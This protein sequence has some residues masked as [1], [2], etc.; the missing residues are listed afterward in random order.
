MPATWRIAALA[1]AFAYTACTSSSGPSPGADRVLTVAQPGGITD[2]V[3]I[4]IA[5]PS[6]SGP[7]P[8]VIYGHGQG[9]GNL[10]HCRTDDA[11]FLASK[12]VADAL[13]REG[14]L[15]I[16]VFYRN[17]GNAAAQLHARDHYILD[18]RA[19]LAAAQLARTELGGGSQVALIGVSMGSFPATWA[20]A[21]LAALADLQAGLDI[22]TVIP[23]AMLGNHLGNT[24]RSQQLLVDLDPNV[25]RTA[26]AFAAF[27]A[28]T[29]PAAAEVRT[30][31]TDTQLL[32]AAGNRLVKQ[33]FLEPACGTQLPAACSP[34][35]M[36]Q[37]FDAIAP[38]RVDAADFLTPEALEA[39]AFWDPP[40]RLDPGAA[41]TNR[42]LAAQRAL[43]PAYVLA[44]PLKTPRM[45]PLVSTGDHVVINQG[46]AAADFYL[47]KLRATGVAIPD[48]VP[49]VR[50]PSC[51]HGDY[52]DPT[53][54]QCG[55]SLVIAELAEAF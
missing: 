48:P 41:T 35:C 29:A 23:T 30:Q 51:G 5:T 26:I 13:A 4:Y 43:S 42:L 46:Q 18:A 20:A 16:A 44:G 15:A 8:V 39:I 50:D 3:P 14:Y 54:P 34:A 28:A 21:S 33:T 49:V 52:F 27:L 38:T 17:R 2:E 9:A 36:A 7:F 31:I 10:V 1:V 55:W 45:L 12:R 25:R 11:D 6:G 32:T 24:G 19:F 40:I 47:A 37:T 53:R 22:V